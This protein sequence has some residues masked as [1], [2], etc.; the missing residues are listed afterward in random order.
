[1]RTIW[2]RVFAVL[3]YAVSSW[4]MDLYPGEVVGIIIDGLADAATRLAPDGRRAHVLAAILESTEAGEVAQVTRER[5]KNVLRGV[6]TIDSRAKRELEDMGFTVTED[7]KHF[8][9]VFQGDDRYTFSL[10]KSGSDHRGG[11]TLPATSPVCSCDAI[12]QTLRP[13]SAC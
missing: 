5:L 4:K 6:R 1:M 2:R 13:A 3:K 7:G 10:P 8:K 11:S 9:L 12:H